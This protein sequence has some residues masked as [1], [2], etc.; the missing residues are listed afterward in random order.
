MTQLSLNPEVNLDAIVDEVLCGKSGPWGLCGD[1]ADYAVILKMLRYHKGAEQALPLRTI[2]TRLGMS[3]RAVKAAVKSLIEDFKLPIGASRQE[4]YGYFLI[5]TPED[6]KK[7]LG[8]LAHELES[9]AV[10]LDV[11]AGSRYVV[12]LLDRVR[13]KLETP[14]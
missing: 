13:L 7:A 14:Q 5:V 11:L 8:P 10:R 6:L 1:Y 4:P 2:S 3:Q 12:D 9:I